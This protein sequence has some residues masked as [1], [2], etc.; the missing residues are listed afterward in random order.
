MQKKIE[1]LAEQFVVSSGANSGDKVMI[2]CTIEHLVIAAS[3]IRK[4][5]DRGIDFELDLS[6]GKDMADIVLAEGSDPNAV[7][8]DVYGFYDGINKV[9]RVEANADPTFFKDFTEEHWRK[10]KDFM[11]HYNRIS[12]TYRDSTRHYTLT[13]IPTL[14]DAEKDQIPYPEYLERFFELCD[15]P[16]D[17][18]EIAQT[19]LIER[20]NRANEIRVTDENGT[21]ITFDITNMTFANSVV[22]KNIPG[23]EVFT[24]PQRESAIGK[25]AARGRFHYVSGEVMEDIELEFKDGRANVVKSQAGNNRLQEIVNTDEGARYIGELAFGTNP[26]LRQHVI[27]GLLVEK[28]GGSFHIAL[29]DAYR[30]TEYNGKPVNL[31]N[32]NESEV[33]WDITTLLRGVGGKVYADGELIQENGEWLDPELEVLNKGWGALPEEERPEWFKKK[34]PNGYQ[35]A[36]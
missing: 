27:N 24:A 19:H 33:H 8:Q 34:F 1:A 18:V 10:A 32:G 13:K 29:G 26:H 15:Q 36:A 28:I 20:L 3:I 30:Y 11:S 17:P 35:Q 4:C 25:I 23:S 5:Q 2:K 16:W 12:D 6:D 9:I 14:Q 31:N 7:G 22:L 21:D